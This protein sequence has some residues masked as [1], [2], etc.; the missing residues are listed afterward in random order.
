MHT[1]YSN[2]V[3]AVGGSGEEIQAREHLSQVLRADEAVRKGIRKRICVTGR[4]KR[5]ENRGEGH[6]LLKELR[7]NTREASAKGDARGITKKTEAGAT[8]QK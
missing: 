8:K 5:T 4:G 1:T 3:E 7:S 2:S 6:V